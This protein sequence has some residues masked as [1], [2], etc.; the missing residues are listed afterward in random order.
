MTASQLTE[1]SKSDIFIENHFSLFLVWPLSS[2][3]ENWIEENVS[4]DCQWFGMALVV[5]PRYL[6]AL[7]EGM[8]ADGLSLV[9]ERRAAQ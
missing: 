4:H 1:A 7:I 2:R 9:G 3:A 5:E 6:R 8:L